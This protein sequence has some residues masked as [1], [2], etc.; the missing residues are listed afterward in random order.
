MILK[1]RIYGSFNISSPLIAALI[2]SKP[3]QRLKNISQMGPPTTFYHIKNYS[4]YEHSIGVFLLLKHL[5]ASD[6]EQI[7][8]LLH[9]VSHTTFSHVIDWVVGTGKNESYQDDQHF[10]FIKKTEIVRILKMNGLS[11]YTVTDYKKYPLLEQ[12]IP[13]LCADR[14]DYA[15]REFDPQTAQSCFRRLTTFNN[16]I[17]FKNKK[18]THTFAHNFLKKQVSH[19]GGYEAV[20]RYRLFADAL[21]EALRKK[22]ITH[23][24][25]TGDEKTVLDKM[26]SSSNLKIARILKTMRQKNLSHLMKT[27]KRHFKKFRFVD[28]YFLENGKLRTLSSEDVS[29]KKE[30]ENARTQNNKGIRIG[31]ISNTSLKNALTTK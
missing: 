16:R 29:F 30:V 8:G 3:F 22:L 12:E 28:P 7:A 20:T 1:D 27:R 23:N 26:T 4:R 19:W 18:S 25:F 24:D 11:L 15:L 9:D 14:I 31:Y 2:E 13:N 10:N 5:G 17:I 21:R 6:N